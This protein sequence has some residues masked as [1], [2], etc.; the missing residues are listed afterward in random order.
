MSNILNIFLSLALVLLSVQLINYSENYEAGQKITNI[1]EIQLDL[2]YIQKRKFISPPTFKFM[3]IKTKQ[4]LI[5]SNAYKTYKITE[6]TDDRKI[7]EVIEKLKFK[8]NYQI[9]MQKITLLNGNTQTILK[10]I[11]QKKEIIYM[12][13]DFHSFGSTYHPDKFLVNY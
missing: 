1:E 9:T 8:D 6:R 4:E 3:G 13:N 2:Q 7:R 11:F 12:S 5:F 10:N